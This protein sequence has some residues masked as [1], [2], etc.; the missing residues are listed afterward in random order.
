M[1]FVT[2]PCNF[3]C[4]FEINKYINKFGKKKRKWKEIDVTYCGREAKK[5]WQINPPQP[6]WSAHFITQNDIINKGQKSDWEWRHEDTGTW[7]LMRE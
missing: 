6:L 3:V 4:L 1:L 2:N 7:E 5:K